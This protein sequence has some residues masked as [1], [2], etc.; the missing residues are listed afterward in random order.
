[1]SFL[2]MRAR[3]AWWRSRPRRW[4]SERRAERWGRELAQESAA[5]LLGRLADRSVIRGRRVPVWAWTNLLAHGAARDLARERDLRRPRGG[6]EAAWQRARGVLA[7]R[8]LD[9]SASGGDLEALQREVLQ[10]LETRLAARR[11]V[12]EWL[13][14][15]WMAVVLEA[16]DE[17]RRQAAT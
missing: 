12:A 8:V 15:Q 1:V 14:E 16:L 2:V 11:E 17:R 9:L 13:P 6:G 7:G 10:P 5:Y 4:F 3:I